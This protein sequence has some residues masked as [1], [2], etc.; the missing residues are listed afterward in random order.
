MRS[1]PRAGAVRQ[2]VATLACTH[3]CSVCLPLDVSRAAQLSNR[4]ATRPGLCLEAEGM[5]EAPGSQR[6]NR[7]HVVVVGL[8]GRSSL[9]GHNCVTRL[10]A[11]RFCL[12]Q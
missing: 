3:R 1:V 9:G 6:L 11:D 2:D 4:E 8:D 5:T 10:F 12:E 7:D